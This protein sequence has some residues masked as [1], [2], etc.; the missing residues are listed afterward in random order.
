MI[1]VT[2]LFSTFRES[3]KL[4]SKSQKIKPRP[5]TIKAVRKL[6]KGRCVST[7]DYSSSLVIVKSVSSITLEVDSGLDLINSIFNSHGHIRNIL[8]TVK[9]RGYRINYLAGCY[10]VANGIGF[11]GHKTCCLSFYINNVSSL[12][13]IE[14]K[15]LSFIEPGFCRPIDRFRMK[16]AISLSYLLTFVTPSPESSDFITKAEDYINQYKDNRISNFNVQNKKMNEINENVAQLTNLVK[17][18]DENMNF[19]SNLSPSH[20]ANVI[21]A[22]EIL[23]K[24]QSK[25]SDYIKMC[26]STNIPIISRFLDR[27]NRSIY[28]KSQSEITHLES[29]AYTISYDKTN[30]QGR[31]EVTFNRSCFTLTPPFTKSKESVYIS[32]INETITRSFKC[33]TDPT[34]DEKGFESFS[35]YLFNLFFSNFNLSQEI[36]E[37]EAKVYI[38]NAILNQNKKIMSFLI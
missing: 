2:D 29:L 16:V 36:S 8:V 31:F 33:P 27:L 13:D 32:V 18:L 11:D 23:S 25:I 3:I 30:G 28:L 38:S 19:I 5:E 26:N 22:Q 7:N 4:L 10:S 20:Q 1:E 14:E 17:S 6:L 12:Q 15:I 34:D 24:C 37:D 35:K 9:I 21:L